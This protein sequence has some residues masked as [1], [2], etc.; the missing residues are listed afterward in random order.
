[1]GEK[2]HVVLRM[3]NYRGLVAELAIKYWRRLLPSTKAWVT[4]DDLLNDGM[5]FAR[6]E[7]MPYFDVRKGC[8]FTTILTISLDHYYIRRV[9][10]L[11]RLKRT[12]VDIPIVR[13]HGTV[14]IIA[15]RM[16][17]TKL[18]EEASPHLQHYIQIWF[19][20]KQGPERIRPTSIPFRKAKKEFL[21]LAPKFSVDVEVCRILLEA[22]KTRS[23]S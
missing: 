12:P 18:Y 17:M 23:L 6:E 21:K 14:D 16:S 9:R 10:D 13:N 7:I 22:R 20:S 19:L 5:L 2:F 11:S 4:E 3:E 15:S 1:M 8:S